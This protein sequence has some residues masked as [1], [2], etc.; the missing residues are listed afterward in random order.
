MMEDNFVSFRVR[1]RGRQQWGKAKDVVLQ[2]P[3]KRNTGSAAEECVMLKPSRL[4]ISD[5]DLVM[6][7]SRC[8]A[9]PSYGYF[10]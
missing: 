2:D 5:N 7:S 3:V 6:F 1:T 10:P 4:V 9:S 8:R